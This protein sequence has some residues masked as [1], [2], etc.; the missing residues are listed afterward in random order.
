M[1]GVGVYTN[2]N[3]RN[4]VVN[5]TGISGDKIQNGK[6][7]VQYISSDNIKHVIFAKAEMEVN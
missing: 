4:V 3:R 7:K 5:L 6:L 1:N 2:I